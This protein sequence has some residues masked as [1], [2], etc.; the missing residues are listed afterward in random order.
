M[1]GGR[2]SLRWSAAA[3][4]VLVWMCWVG[5]TSLCVACTGG[6]PVG[7]GDVEP[8]SDLPSLAD[9]WEED[10]DGDGAQGEDALSDDDSEA[11][12]DIDADA[13]ADTDAVEEEDAMREEDALPDDPRAEVEVGVP[14][15]QPCG[16]GVL[17]EGEE[18]DEGPRN[19]DTLADRCRRDCRLPRCG[20]GVRDTAEECD[21]GD[22][23]GD[24]TSACSEGCRVVVEEACPV[25]A[26]TELAG[27][28][29]PTLRFVW[30]GAWEGI[31][32]VAEVPASCWDEDTLEGPS[33]V[34]LYV[35]RVSSPGVYALAGRS[36]EGR[37]P[38]VLSLRRRC[39]A[40]VFQCGQPAAGRLPAEPLLWVVDRPFVG[41]LG[42]SPGEPGAARYTIEMEWMGA[43]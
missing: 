43:P 19:S 23:N 2:S 8:G 11:D 22:R 27:L 17:D 13:V 31:D 1:R 5:A 34:N 6:A 42:V 4:R 33:A 16:N 14:V 37:L 25:E 10:E 18:C 41:F 36:E 20:D 26:F 9:R 38:P 15:D 30:E 24:G 29:E 21:E 3:Q 39:D 7:A 12:D 28:R 40:P 35:V 32:P